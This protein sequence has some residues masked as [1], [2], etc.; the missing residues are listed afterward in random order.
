MAGA[1]VINS[2][3]GSGTGFRSMYQ[4]EEVY[5]SKAWFLGKR[6]NEML[7]RTRSENRV[8]THFF[9]HVFVV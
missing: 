4:R 2:M 9:L 1:I 7:Q 6:N 5:E 3:P 8:I